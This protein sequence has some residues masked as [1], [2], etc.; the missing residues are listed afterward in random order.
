MER[1]L[2]VIKPDAV[3]RGISGEIIQRFEKTGLK[4]IGAK[5][6]VVD[7][8]LANKHYPRD[9]H[10][11]IE[12]IGKNTLKSYEEQS[13]DVKAQFGTKD[14]HEIGLT[15]QVWLVDFIASAPVLALVL[16]GPHAIEVVRKLVGVTTPVAA[17]P[18][19]IR[20]DYSF[21]SPAAANAGQ[22]PI[23]NLIH[24]SGNKA[25]AEYEI[26]LWFKS[27]ELFDYDAIHQKHMTR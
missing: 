26:K 10:D 21:D 3:Q 27:A 9:R 13:M 7:K 5:M 24:A 12:G 14:P 20:G 15:V 18:G 19:T 22:R 8:A 4:I 16:D 23:R 25:E 11:F 2:V 6:F 17:Q 1:T